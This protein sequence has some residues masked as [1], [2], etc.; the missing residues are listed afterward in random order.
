MMAS[1]SR[2][3]TDE[4]IEFYQLN[5][6]VAIR[7]LLPFDDLQAIR[8]AV[9]DAYARHYESE[10]DNTGANPAYDAVFL[11]K[12]N[13]WQVHEG[14]R[15]HTTSPRLAECARI[16]MGAANV[17]VWHDQTLVKEP[18]SPP[19]PFHQDLPYWPMVEDTA[20]TAW[21]ALDDVDERNSCM[22]YIPGSQAW[23][24]LSGVDFTSPLG[25]AEVAPD[26]AGE[27]V[28]VSVPVPAGSVVFHHSLTFHGAT[29]N[30][31]DRRRRAMI[32]HYMADGTHFNGQKHMVTDITAIAPGDAMTDD[33]LWPVV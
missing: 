2:L 15:R 30:I 8:A 20:L 3:I 11:Q 27:C 19:T 6:Y 1:T 23:G 16:L 7:D 29:A 28:A 18:G 13:L 14:I 32:V 25:V 33:A 31:T 22:Q 4:H 12:V 10:H 21:T 17:R 26:H 24:R 5:G 9:D